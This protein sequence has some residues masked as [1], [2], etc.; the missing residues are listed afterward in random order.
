MTKKYVKD[1]GAILDYGFDWSQ[2]LA[3]GE[4]IAISEWEVDEGLTGSMEAN[5]ST[6]TQIRLAGGTVGTT[7]RAINR[8]TTTAGQVDERTI[9]VR[10]AER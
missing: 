9:S 2:W 10:I 1:P 4:T 6:A 7:Y 5:T 8:V 3:A